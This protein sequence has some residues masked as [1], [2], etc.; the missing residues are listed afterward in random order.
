VGKVEVDAAQERLAPRKLSE[1]IVPVPETGTT[2]G[3]GW[4]AAHRILG[5][6]RR[7]D[8]HW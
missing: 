2:A 5:D 8:R 3:A 1:A 7:A 6:R 4:L